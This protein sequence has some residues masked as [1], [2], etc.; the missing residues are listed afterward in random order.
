M[1]TSGEL[2]HDSNC[3]PSPTS[4]AASA[5]AKSTARPAV[6]SYNSG[7]DMSSSDASGTCYGEDVLV[8]GGSGR[9]CGGSLGG[10][11]S[12]GVGYISGGSGEHV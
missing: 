2:R 12:G 4:V 3:R 9:S 1:V 6:A 5:A 10:G 7:G 8:R 11:G